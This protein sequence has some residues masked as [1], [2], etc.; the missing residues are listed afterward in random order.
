LKGWSKPEKVGVRKNEKD[1]N[2]SPQTTGEKFFRKGKGKRS[3]SSK[4]KKQQ[5]EEKREK[6]S[7]K[8][9]EGR[10]KKK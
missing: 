1:R 10:K 4:E 5:R 6:E 7:T 9:K 8:K 2:S 3:R